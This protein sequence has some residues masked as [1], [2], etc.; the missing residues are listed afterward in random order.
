[1]VP[2]R[3]H[4]RRAWSSLVALAIVVSGGFTTAAWSGPTAG[5]ISTFAGGLGSGTPLAVP[6]GPVSVATS[7]RVI[8][9]ADLSSKVVRAIDRQTSNE[10]VVA[11]SGL[12][13]QPNTPDGIRAVDLRFAAPTAV[14]IGPDGD[15]YVAEGGFD[16]FWFHETKVW[17]VDRVSG[18]ATTF[19]GG[20]A[21]QGACEPDT[22]ACAPATVSLMMPRALAFDRAGNLFIADAQ[23]NRVLRLDAA[24]KTVHTVAGATGTLGTRQCIEV[25]GLPGDGDGGPATLA[26][27]SV[28][29]GLALDD[30]GSHLLIADTG[31]DKVRQVDLATGLITTVAGSPQQNVLVRPNGAPAL[32]VNLNAPTGVAYDASGGFFI[33]VQHD[34]LHVD[35]TAMIRNV[36]PNVGVDL[37]ALTTDTSGGLLVGDFEGMQLLAVQADGT[38]RRVAG[39]GKCCSGGNGGLATGAVLFNANDLAVDPAGQVFLAESGSVGPAYAGFVRRVDRSN[40]ITMFAGT[41]DRGSSGDGGPAVG[42][43]LDMPTSEAVDKQGAIYIGDIGSYRIRRV[44]P[45]GTISTIAGAGVDGV[46]GEAVVATLARVDP[47]AMAVDPTGRVVFAEPSQIRRIDTDGRI[48][49]IAGT[50]QS[51]GWGGYG[52]D[53]GPA[54]QAQFCGI[55]DIAFDGVGNLLVADRGNHRIRSISPTGQV[56]TIAGSGPDCNFTEVASTG[57]GGPATSAVFD[58]RAI[59]PTRSG[60]LYIADK[61]SVRRVTAEGM[62]STFAGNG[63][64]ELSG[65]G[66]QATQAGVGVVLRIAV[67]ENAKKLYI[68][69]AASFTIGGNRVRVVQLP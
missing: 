62:T 25:C 24:S 26:A 51:G 61:Y 45:A 31:H 38:S 34:L 8:Y 50:D 11:G 29:S 32:A 64:N 17:R 16:A 6:Q 46:R 35:A 13:Y 37:E 68:L 9:V 33:T 7:G 66:G 60:D 49:T 69:Q 2:V 22:T 3:G 36:A 41:G 54:L 10:T 30:A 65:D 63:A 56:A 23:R 5:T 40:H 57:D 28:P 67:D 59:V 39:T 52:G 12:P 48:R 14:A 27:L 21:T 47:R 44:D 55:E 18:T 58:P 1:L 20:A 19:L 42:A 43:R 4:Q 53:G 15:L